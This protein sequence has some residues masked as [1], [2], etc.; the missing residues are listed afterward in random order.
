MQEKYNEIKRRLA[1]KKKEITDLKQIVGSKQHTI[2]C[3]LA[4]KSS[5]ASNDT[6]LNEV[7]LLSD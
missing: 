3:L 5:C 2:N 7:E 1:D 4:L 6:S